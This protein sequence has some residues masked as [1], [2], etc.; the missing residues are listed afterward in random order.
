MKTEKNAF[1]VRIQS[2]KRCA[3]KDIFK[4]EKS[5][6]NVANKNASEL[7]QMY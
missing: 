3:K 2:F 6:T 7:L 1:K 5:T 4:L